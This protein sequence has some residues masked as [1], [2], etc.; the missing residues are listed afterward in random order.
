MQA[1]LLDVQ[2]GYSSDPVSG[3]YNH[4]WIIG[5][6]DAISIAQQARLDAL[7][8]IVPV[9]TPDAPPTP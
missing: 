8:E 9:R 3:V 1:Y 6:A 7:L 5:N 2:P 4:G